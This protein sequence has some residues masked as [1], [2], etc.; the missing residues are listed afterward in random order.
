MTSNIPSAEEVTE[1]D[2]EILIGE[3]QVQ[4]HEQERSLLMAKLQIKKAERATQKFRD[5]ILSLEDA[6]ANTKAQI[7]DLEKGGEYK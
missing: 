6:I 4:L 3:A 1:L 5:T 2:R 7:A